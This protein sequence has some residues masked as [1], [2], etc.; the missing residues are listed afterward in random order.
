MTIPTRVYVGNLPEDVRY[1]EVEDIFGAHGL[2]PL[3]G[4][5]DDTLAFRCAAALGPAASRSECAVLC[6]HCA[7]IHTGVAGALT[8]TD[9]WADGLRLS[10]SIRSC[11]AARQQAMWMRVR[12]QVPP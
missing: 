2:K 10:A 8:R 9:V 7:R 4:L 5:A 12:R 1:E 6:M 11:F 3:E